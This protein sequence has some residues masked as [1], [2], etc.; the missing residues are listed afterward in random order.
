V[1]PSLKKFFFTTFAIPLLVVA[2]DSHGQLKRF[3]AHPVRGNQAAA[4]ER[5]QARTKETPP[6]ALPFFDDF[7]KANGVYADTSLWENSSSVWV[8]DGMAIRPPTI[9]VAT[10]D[11]LNSSGIPYNS[12]EVL[13]TGYTDTLMSRPIDL[14]ESGVSVAERSSVYLSFMYQWQGNVEPPDEE[15]FLELSFKTAE[16]SSGYAPSG[17]CPAPMTCGT[18]I[19][20]T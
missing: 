18:L 6:L 7:S 1:L 10:F 12:N 14:S 13:L 19:I 16:E 9:N 2:Y 8:N 5:V 17:G 15:D 4:N 20:F 11:G 3:P